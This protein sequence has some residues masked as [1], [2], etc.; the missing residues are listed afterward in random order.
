MLLRL[1]QREMT[2]SDTYLQIRKGLTTKY[3]I[4]NYEFPFPGDMYLIHNPRSGGRFKINGE[5]AGM[6]LEKKD[7]ADIY[8]R[9]TY[10]IWQCNHAN[11]INES[12]PRDQWPTI[13]EKVFADAPHWN[14][15]PI[16]TRMHNILMLLY[17]H[18]GGQ[19]GVQLGIVDDSTRTGP[20]FINAIDDAAH[21]TFL[22]MKAAAY[23]AHD[24]E[25]MSLLN[26]MVDEK[27]LDKEK[28]GYI[29]LKLTTS[30][31]RI[32]EE[33]RRTQSASTTCFVAMWFDDSMN[34]LYN[35]AI[36][37]AIQE[38]GYMLSRIDYKQHNNKIDDEIIA[39]I[40]NAKFMVADF[41]SSKEMVKKEDEK[42]SECGNVYYEAGFA[43]ALDKPVISLCR[44][45]YIKNKKIAFDTQAYNHI[46]W[47]NGE[48][49]ALKEAIKHRIEATIGKGP[50]QPSGK[51][52]E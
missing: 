34:S 15:P 24:T 39:G 28:N 48:W 13:S 49:D 25:F 35:R 10:W 40:R 22:C 37:P 11:K 32:L 42:P 52:S 3:R 17:E 14:I 36:E 12:T 9:L 21:N 43:R 29:L 45:D 1:L 38:A 51:K 8:R 31:Y 16:D 46:T 47:E 26:A 2:N 44:K 23:S 5:A 7:E 19:L 4:D 30:G 20:S 41:T 18:I 6:Y 50:I 33:R 27:I